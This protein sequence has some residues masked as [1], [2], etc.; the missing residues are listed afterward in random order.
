MKKIIV[1]AIVLTNVFLACKKDRT[2]SC[3]LTTK[4]TATTTAAITFSTPFGNLPLVDTSFTT[5]VYEKYSYDKTIKKAT[6]NTAKK[7]CI[8]YEEPYRE[9]ILNDA[10]PLQIVNVAEGVRTY[11]CKLK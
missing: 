6:R 5:P 4:G 10:P 1:A 8:N 3:S 7:N 9:V 11:E 2:C